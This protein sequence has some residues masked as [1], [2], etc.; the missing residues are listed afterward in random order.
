MP[1][2]D[3]FAALPDF[4]VGVLLPGLLSAAALDCGAMLCVVFPELLAS[5]STTLPEPP[6]PCSVAAAPG[7]VLPVPG[8][9]PPARSVGLGAP[10]AWRNIPSMAIAPA[11]FVW[12]SSAVADA[13][14]DVDS[15]ALGG[16]AADAT[17]LAAGV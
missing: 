17:G 5:A 13:A 3:A 11:V 9:V 2:G 14:T 1:P 16:V 15:L 8:A 10:A 12:S 4:L 7:D 6:G